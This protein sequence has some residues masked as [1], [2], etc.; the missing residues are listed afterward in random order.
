ME[1][2]TTE[3]PTQETAPTTAEPAATAWFCWSNF[4]WHWP[5][6]L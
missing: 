4:G 5:R 2:T 3:Q 1:S 6:T